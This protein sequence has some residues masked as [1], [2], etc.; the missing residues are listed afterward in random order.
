MKEQTEVCFVGKKHYH[1]WQGCVYCL[2]LAEGNSPKKA[3]CEYASKTI[4]TA[5]VYLLNKW[6]FLI[7][8]TVG[9]VFSEKN[10]RYKSLW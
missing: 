6:F 7:N 4:S 3:G 10:I 5:F 1:K 2:C 9:H 8:G